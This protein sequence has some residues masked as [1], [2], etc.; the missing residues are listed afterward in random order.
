MQGYQ[1]AGGQNPARQLGPDGGTGAIKALYV[2]NL[3]PFVTEV[4]LQVHALAGLC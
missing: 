1:P 4:M 2:G 3:H